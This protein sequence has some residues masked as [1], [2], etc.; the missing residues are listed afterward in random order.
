MSLNISRY[1]LAILATILIVVITMTLREDW[2][3]DWVGYMKIY[4][5]GAWLANDNRDPGFLA[6]LNTVKFLPGGDY[7]MFRYL[8]VVYF[9]VFIFFLGRGSII[10][11]GKKH[12]AFISILFVLVCFSLV[13]FSIQ[14]REGIAVTF[15]I[16]AV[17]V[18]C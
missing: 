5:D 13:R 16:F 8:V 2:N 15:M 18:L 14:I 1:I 7:E 4:E 10:E 11:Y 3:P 17:S 12:C 9:A 6:I